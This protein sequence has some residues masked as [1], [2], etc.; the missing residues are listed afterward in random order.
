MHC[1]FL[2]GI[3]DLTFFWCYLEFQNKHYSMNKNFY[4][5]VI[6]EYVLSDQTCTHPL[7]IL[8]I[9]SILPSLELLLESTVGMTNKGCTACHPHPRFEIHGSHGL[10]LLPFPPKPR[11]S[12]WA[13]FNTTIH[14][15][16]LANWKHTKMR[17]AFHPWFR[18]NFQVPEFTCKDLSIKIMLI[19]HIAQTDRTLNEG[20]AYPTVSSLST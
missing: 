13:V 1:L 19:L 4:T 2:P 3:K 6:F 12:T 16:K 18:V 15:V 14:I 9:V 10:M 20:A 5:M 17:S 8:N 11:H 7:L